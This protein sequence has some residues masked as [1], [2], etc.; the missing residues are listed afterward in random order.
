M[1]DRRRRRQ[2]GLSREASQEEVL[3]GDL[4]GVQRIPAESADGAKLEYELI[5]CELHDGARQYVASAKMLLESLRDEQNDSLDGDPRRLDMALGL[6]ERADK[7]LRRLI[8][9]LQPVQ[10]QDTRAL[11][12][13]SYLSDE[14]EMNSGPEI[15]WCLDSEFDELPNHLKLPVLRILQECLANVRRHSMTRRVLVGISRDERSVWL[16]VQDWGVGFDPNKPRPE[17]HGLNG[18]RQ[19]AR[20][21]N[22]TV[23][24]ESRLGEGTCIVVEFPLQVHKAPAGTNPSSST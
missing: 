22:G 8:G 19:R 24:I 12:I 18:I 17:C 21:L 23:T 4:P 9:G 3:P 16:Q 11:A 13:I 1:V 14:N 2:R 20:L 7:E 10:F 15:E 5:G 6:L